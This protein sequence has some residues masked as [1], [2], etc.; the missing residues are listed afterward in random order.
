MRMIPVYQNRR[1]LKTP[2]F[3]FPA[4][5]LAALLITGCGGGSG[6]NSAGDDPCQQYATKVM[7]CLKSICTSHS[8]CGVCACTPGSCCTGYA[9]PAVSTSCTGSNRNYSTAG[10]VNFSCQSND[11]VQTFQSAVNSQCY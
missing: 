10:L 5:A 8:S 3:L 11:T 9:C 4:L 1:K 2:P 6:G 7:D